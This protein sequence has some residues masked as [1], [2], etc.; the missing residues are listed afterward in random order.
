LDDCN[1]DGTGGCCND[2]NGVGAV[3]RGNVELANRE[4]VLNDDDDND[5]DDDD[6][7]DESSGGGGGSSVRPAALN[8]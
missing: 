5:D 6:G 4:D 3:G 1:N 7:E 2:A 8:D